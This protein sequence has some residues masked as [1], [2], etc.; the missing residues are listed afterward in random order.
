MARDQRKIESMPPAK[1]M[2]TYAERK[3]IIG[4]LEYFR[5]L[6]W[7][8]TDM[9]DRLAEIDR[10][11]RHKAREDLGGLIDDAYSLMLGFDLSFLV[12]CQYAL[13]GP[14]AAWDG[15][16]AKGKCNLP[17]EMIQEDLDRLER[18]ENHLMK[19]AESYGKVRHLLGVGERDEATRKAAAS[20]SRFIKEMGGH[21]TKATG[22]KAGVG[23]E[24]KHTRAA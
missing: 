9:A 5:R 18:I 3:D 13:R 6:H 14:L 11:L 16:I 21:G 2:R 24:R 17:H 8:L 19:I 23:K 22:G 20:F 1:A 4:M 15:Q 10:A 7:S 12:R